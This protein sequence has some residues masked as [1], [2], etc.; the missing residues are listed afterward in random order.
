MK[1][2]CLT[3]FGNTGL[4]NCVSAFDVTKQLIF[5]PYF[6]EDGTINGIDLTGL[7]GLDQAFIDSKIKALLPDDRWYITPEIK[8]VTDERAEDVTEEFDDTTSV[9]IQEGARTFTGIVV[10]APPQFKGELDK[11]RCVKG[12]YYVVDKSG[13]LIGDNSREGFL[14]PIRIQDQSL[15]VGFVKGTDTTIQKVSISFTVSMTMDDANI[16]MIESSNISGTLLGA[17]GLLS[18]Y[19]ESDSSISTAGFTVTLGANYGGVLSKTKAK[20][21]ELADFAAFNTTQSS[22]ETLASVTETSDGVYAFVYDSAVTAADLITVSN[23]ASGD[24]S[25]G[26]DIVPFTILTP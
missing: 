18:V 1:C 12:G 21:L 16:S 6:K 24:L 5:V 20:G 8:N 23:K 22:A 19:K 17:R 11:I 13:N 25:K 15:S 10:G 9:F 14:D 3:G 7:T 4:P 26:Y 2:T